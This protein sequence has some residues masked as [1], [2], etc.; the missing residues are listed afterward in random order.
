MKTATGM[1]MHNGLKEMIFYC[2]AGIAYFDLHLLTRGNPI[3]SL[4]VKSKTCFK[5]QLET[6]QIQDREHFENFSSKQSLIKSMC[7]LVFYRNRRTEFD[8]I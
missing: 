5:T 3:F 4:N 7:H 8:R 6:G 2:V 1:L